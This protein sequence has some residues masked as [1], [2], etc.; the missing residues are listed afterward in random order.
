[1]N[2]PVEG[3]TQTFERTFTVEEVQQFAELS[4]D[5]QPRHTEPDEDGRVMVQG[6]LTA[7]MPTKLGGD[8]GVLASNMEFEFHQPVYTGESVTCTSTY[9]TVVERDNRY[10]FSADVV[11]ENADGEPVLTGTV[12]GLIWKDD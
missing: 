5:A 8:D 3:K 7:T 2:P 12:D 4:G 1:M 6:L 10:E 9:D 11:C